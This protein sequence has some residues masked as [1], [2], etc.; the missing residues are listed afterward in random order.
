MTLRHLT[1]LACA[2]MLTSACN[3]ADDEP[4]AES[5]VPTPTLT[6]SPV[7]T[8]APD[9]TAIVPGK[10]DVSEDATS[11]RAVYAEE[12]GAPSLTMMCDNAT[13]VATL[14][15]A[16]PA[17]GPQAF[18]LEAGGN[19]ARLDMLP[20]ANGEEAMSAAIEPGLPIFAAFSQA[21]TVIALTPPGGQKMQFPTNGGIDRVIAACR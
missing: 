8:A 10:W 7:P 2:A 5:P 16:G 18:V 12:G 20:A 3:S 6:S 4:A 1:L 17:P 21:D 15:I 14:T 13:K 11:T 9:G 19:A